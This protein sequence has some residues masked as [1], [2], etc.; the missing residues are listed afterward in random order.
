MEEEEEEKPSEKKFVWESELQ[1]DSELLD[2]GE[3][4]SDYC[5]AVTNFPRDNE[6]SS[7]SEK[8]RDD[9]IVETVNFSADDS[10]QNNLPLPRRLQLE[11]EPKEKEKVRE[12][13]LEDA[14]PSQLLD[15][16]KKVEEEG[17][18]SL[19][20]KAPERSDASQN[21]FLED[22]EDS[23]L[24]ARPETEVNFD[25]NEIDN[26]DQPSE[27]DKIVENELK[28]E[29]T[30][31]PR[32]DQDDLYSSWKRGKSLCEKWQEGEGELVS[33]MET[34]NPR[35]NVADNERVVVMEMAK[36]KRAEIMELS[37]V[38]IKESVVELSLEMR[39][40]EEEVNQQHEEE[41]GEDIERMIK[42]EMMEENKV[43]DSLMMEKLRIVEERMI[44]SEVTEEERVIEEEM[45][46]LEITGRRQIEC[47][48]CKQ[49][50]GEV[51]Q[52]NKIQIKRNKLKTN[53]RR[54]VEAL[55]LSKYA[56]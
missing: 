53:S 55:S 42:E 9:L 14:E 16:L 2:L 12:M 21:C 39:E 22:A 37:D 45:L 6:D 33:E 27:A 28:S 7:T 17:V 48:Y 30:R 1:P 11:R 40:M 56:F 50:E 47:N 41:E 43:R 38:S 54:M 20:A 3:G 23:E 15:K 19:K 34:R 4:S 26:F 29:S 24:L 52:K 46:D 10:H 18:D 35:E 25:A 31:I 5:D 51:R 44:N 36:E 13:L 32:C 8:P 49:K